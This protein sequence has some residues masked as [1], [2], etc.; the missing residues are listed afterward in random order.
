MKP[1]FCVKILIFCVVSFISGCSHQTIPLKTVYSSGN[2]AISE[3]MTKS[4]HSEQ[5]LDQ[6]LKLLQR[7][8]SPKPRLNE[9]IDF[10]KQA[11]ILFTLGQKPSSGYAISLHTNEAILKGQK[12]YLPIQIKQ[13]DKNRFQ[14]QVLTSPCSIFA[15][16]KSDIREIHLS[17][18]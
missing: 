12:L 13:P 2:C 6:I 18:K 15:I 16:P 10:G 3:S 7:K 9:H 4:I 17:T 1:D 8:F 14:A 5:E 11:L